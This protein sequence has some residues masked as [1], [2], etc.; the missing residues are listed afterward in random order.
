MNLPRVSAVAAGSAVLANNEVSEMRRRLRATLTC[1]VSV[2]AFTGCSL[3][4]TSSVTPD[5]TPG[6]ASSSTHSSTAK[7][8]GA[9]SHPTQEQAFDQLI[10]QQDRVYRVI[11]PLIVKNAVL[12]KTAARPLLGFTAKN[13]YSYPAEL[14]DAAIARLGTDEALRI[15]Q[16]LDGSGAQRAG[17]QRGDALIAIA[18]KPIP[19]GPQAETETARV[20]APLLRQTTE[21]DVA[22][23]RNGQ[24]MTLK[25]ALTTACAFTIDIGNAPHVNAYSDGRRI[26]VTTGLLAELSDQ[27]LAVI[28][29]REI[30]HNVQQHAAAMQTRATMAAIIDTLLPPTPDLSGFAGSAGLKPMDEKLDQEAD[31]MALY[32]L[33]RT[34]SDLLSAIATLDRLAQ[35]YPATVLNSYTAL[36]PWTGERQRQMRDTLAEIRKKQAGKKPLVP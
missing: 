10:A 1:L 14:R 36:H 6:S 29:A 16:V 17:V 30:A 2:L 3:I 19:Q 24:P 11:A 7:P 18:G 28:L 20:L 25:V 12:C 15:V 34:G 4:S 35:R 8:R 33:A 5:A 21:V 22:L 27:E 26:M 23:L 31:R 9:R 32:M 13:R